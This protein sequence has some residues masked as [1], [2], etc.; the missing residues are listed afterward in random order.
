MVWLSL[1]EVVG[2]EA[3]L[4]LQS[5]AAAVEA[6][7][8]VVVATAPRVAATTTTTLVK[9]VVLAAKNDIKSTGGGLSAQ[10]CKEAF[11]QWPA[12]DY[13]HRPDVT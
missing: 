3:I 5:A 8:G 12:R 2:L 4:G 9:N 7:E 6:F 11:F 1:G 10:V 13:K